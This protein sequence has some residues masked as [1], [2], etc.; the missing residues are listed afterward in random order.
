MKNN[1]IN[2]FESTVKIL[3]EGKNV[4]NYVKRL[5]KQ[6]IYIFNLE[7][8]SYNKVEIIIKY[9]DYLSLKD[10][11]SIYKLEVIEKYGKLKI[12]D[13]LKKNFIL[14]VS[15]FIGLIIIVMLSNVIFNVEVIHTNKEIVELISSELD[16]Y[17]IKK[18]KLKKSYNDIEKIEDRILENN[19]DK[20]EWREIEEVGTKYIVRVE[21][22]KIKE[23]DNNNVVN[24]IVM[25]KSG[26]LKKVLAISGEKIRELNTFVS[27]G[28]IVISGKITKPNGE[29]I[30]TSAKGLVYAEVWY[31]VDVE[32]PYHYKEE[33]LTGNKKDVYYIKFLNKRISLFDFKKYNS[34]K[35]NPKVIMYNSILPIAFVK[36]RQYEVNVID[37]IYTEEQVI[38][39]AIILA[40][41]RL[42]NSNTKIDSIDK[43]SV[44]NKED[45]DSKI[46]LNLFISVIEEVGEVQEINV[47]EDS[48][49]ISE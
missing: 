23:K 31:T 27:K 45:L 8:I 5:I 16:N 38:D 29:T 17:D 47:D 25:S 4:N 39:R 7:Y 46:K 24:N 36:E 49:E 35:S 21:E 26:V 37:E 40:E 20:L 12:K 1:I 22:R 13:I 10:S 19:K 33:I 43:V 30:L 42:L 48:N 15:L 44:I 3:V 34:F 28:D 9:S 41:E 32:Y 2:K 14:L 11:K 18:Y 6:N